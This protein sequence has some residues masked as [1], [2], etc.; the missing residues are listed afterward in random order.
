MRLRQYRKRRD[1]TQPKV[2]R[3]FF[4]NTVIVEFIGTQP[5]QAIPHES[6]L[7]LATSEDLEVN[8]VQREA[9]MAKGVA[10]GNTAYQLARPLESRLL[11][12]Y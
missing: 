7:F 11:G 2:T 3:T 10:V 1:A 4:Q 6:M 9:N 5:L 8:L 12:H